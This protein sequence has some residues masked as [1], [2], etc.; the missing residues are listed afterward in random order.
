M[1]AF[2]FFCSTILRVIKSCKMRWAGHVACIDEMRNFYNILV[3][4]TER[5]RPLEG[6]GCSCE[7]NIRMDLR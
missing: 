5:K 2:D 1:Q 4:K 3:G 7:D 6:L